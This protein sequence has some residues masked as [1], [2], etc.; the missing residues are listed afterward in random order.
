MKWI[1]ITKTDDLSATCGVI[2]VLLTQNDTRCKKVKERANECEECR[3]Y[4]DS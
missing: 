1:V 4:M 3:V 2:S